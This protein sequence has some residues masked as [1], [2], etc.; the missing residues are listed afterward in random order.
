MHQPGHADAYQSRIDAAGRVV[1][2]AAL[3]KEAGIHEGDTLIFIPT[4]TGLEIKTYQQLV[5]EAQALFCQ[6]APADRVLSEE[7]ITERRADAA[8]D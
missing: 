4:R 3:R 1:I 7:I 2:P 5:D 6:A 8:N